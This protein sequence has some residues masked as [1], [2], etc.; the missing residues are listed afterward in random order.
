MN[1]WQKWISINIL[2]LGSFGAWAQ[3]DSLVQQADRLTGW[4]AYGRA[5]ELYTQLLAKKASMTVAQQ[6][7]VQA[8]L[9]NAYQQVGDMTKAERVYHDWLESG[10]EFK[11]KSML[12]YA[13]ALASNGKFKEAQTMYE[14]YLSLK[15]KTPVRSASAIPAGPLT[16]PA[17]S[18][19]PAQPARYRLDVLGID[20][21]NEEFSPAYYKNG[22]VYVSGSKG[23]SSIETSGSGGGSGY[24]DLVYVPDRSQLKV[25]STISADGVETKVNPESFRD[26]DSRRIG[27]DD[28]TRPTANDSRTV[29][30]FAGGINI[31]EGLGYEARSVNPA[32][33]FSKSLNTRY[34]EGPATFSSDGRRIIFTRN[35]TT[36]GRAR[37]SAEGVTKLKLYTAEQQNGTWMNVTEFP[38]N[39]DEYSVGH[40]TL[41]KDDQLLIFASDIPGGF[42][43]TDLYYSRWENGQWSTP[44]TLGNT[45]NTK[46]NELFPF[47]DESG[48]L[49]FSSDGRPG[50]G[51]L[52]LFYAALNGTT[53]QSVDHLD[54]PINSPQDDF[55]IITDGMRRGGYF[56]SS[57]AG[58]DDIFRF[59][60][61][62]SLYGCRNLAIRLYDTDTDEPLD[63]V[64]VEVKAN[65]E[66]RADQQL[67]TD[68]NGLLQLCLDADNDFMFRAA[69]DGYIN[70]TIG[71]S[72]RF[73]TDDQPSR[74]EIGLSKPTAIIDTLQPIITREPGTGLTRSRVRGSVVSDRD[75][76]PI[77]GVLVKLKNECNGQVMSTTTGPD[78]SYTFNITEGC[79]YT[80]I[81]SKEKYGTNMSRIKKLPQKSKPKEVAADLHMLSVGDI[82]TI[83]NIYY[84][85]DRTTLRADAS[86]EL[87]K[88]VTTMRRY[89]TLV[90]EIRSHTDSRGD[91]NYNRDLST[92]RARAVAAYLVS[93]GISKRRIAAVGL[94]ESMLVNNCVDGVICT[95][96]EHQRNR[97]TEF[98]VLAIK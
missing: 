96:A 71:F 40:P 4:R 72:T 14:R 49:Y 7:A 33:Q 67:V 76:R 73:L 22:L 94:G 31:T 98:K 28:Y 12:L 30:N 23:G 59:I 9:A 74:L 16:K 53:V 2:W 69:R 10:V 51:G 17:G 60:R 75:R 58:S 55:G 47:I 50:L 85:L 34:H 68:R 90:I 86:R 65:G 18:G 43:G 24:L 88:L 84:D 38:Y 5:I 77:E 39:S 80:L 81:A 56:S 35:N 32:Q 3:V 61:E 63:S 62:S 11:P 52:D 83:D 13:Q 82:V 6:A 92:R 44:I 79:D 64:T 1:F 48:N 25:K 42:G 91:A 54:A 27:S 70:S 20:T 46:G 37:K 8:G 57:R 66:G 21:D 97:R 26:S 93:K 15:E 78:G 45:I 29:P 41:S 89:P 87:D 19:N 95:E 36:G